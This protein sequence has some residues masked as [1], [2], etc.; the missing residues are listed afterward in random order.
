MGTEGRPTF[1]ARQRMAFRPPSALRWRVSLLFFK[2]LCA[3]C[4][5]L[6]AAAFR[7]S[8]WKAVP[9]ATATGYPLSVPKAT[10]V[11]QTQGFA[12]DP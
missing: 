11:T 2:R 1:C 8:G 10:S 4:T 5:A 6:R 9:A 7:L 3:G 12:T